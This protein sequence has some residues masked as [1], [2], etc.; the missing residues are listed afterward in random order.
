MR[1]NAL[2]C[3]IHIIQWVWI[4]HCRQW[5]QE[6]PI[7]NFGSRVAAAFGRTSFCIDFLQR[8]GSQQR[9]RPRVLWHSHSAQQFFFLSLSPFTLSLSILIITRKS[10]AMATY[11]SWRPARCSR[12]FTCRRGTRAPRP[13][14]R[15]S[16]SRQP[17]RQSAYNKK[18][19]ISKERS[20]NYWWILLQLQMYC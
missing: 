5:I 15:Q 3:I 1:V 19:F 6:H 11:E 18:T 14:V 4:V 12:H 13:P 9:E 7:P 2:Y 20:I 8:S 10:R 17:V 16:S